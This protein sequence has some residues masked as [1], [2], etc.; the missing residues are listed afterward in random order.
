MK[1]QRLQGKELIEKINPDKA[2]NRRFRG[3]HG[4]VDISDC[5][6]ISDYIIE[7]FYKKKLIFCRYGE[8]YVLDLEKRKKSSLAESNLP[9]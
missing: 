5:I 3:D 6:S 2:G 7:S 1:L 4:D 8:K 9:S